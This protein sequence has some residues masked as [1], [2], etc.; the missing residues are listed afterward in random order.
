MGANYR[1]EPWNDQR[2]AVE[3]FISFSVMADELLDQE[4]LYALIEA[5]DHENPWVSYYEGGEQAKSIGVLI[6]KEVEDGDEHNA[7]SYVFELRPPFHLKA[8]QFCAYSQYLSVLAEKLAARDIK[9]VGRVSS[10]MEIRGGDSW[11]S[12][13]TADKNLQPYLDAPGAQALRKLLSNARQGA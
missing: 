3:G 7:R 9:G 6:A 8:K 12:T 13:P 10:R 11:H 5:V 4:A 1:K 2:F